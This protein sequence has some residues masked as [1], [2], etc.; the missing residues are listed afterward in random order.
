MTNRAIELRSSKS[1]RRPH[2]SRSISRRAGKGIVALLKF[3]YDSGWRK[4]NQA[5]MRLRVIA[6][7]VSSFQNFAR[8]VRI[9]ANIFPDLKERGARLVVVEQIEQSGSY[10]GVGPVIK[11]Q[12]DSRF[13]ARSPD[14]WS[15]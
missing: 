6:D 9:R 11:R 14:C 13:V 10:R 3:L 5:G 2:P 12:G 8:E 1:V 4:K 7:S 15:E